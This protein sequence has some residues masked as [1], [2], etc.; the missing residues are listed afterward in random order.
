MNRDSVPN[1]PKVPDLPVI[2]EDLPYQDHS[3]FELY[4]ILLENNIKVDVT[5]LSWGG[6][7]DMV[8]KHNIEVPDA[9]YSAP[10]WMLEMGRYEEFAIRINNPMFYI[11]ENDI[12]RGTDG[13][14]YLVDT[15]YFDNDDITV[16]YDNNNS[17]EDVRNACRVT[18][19]DIKTG[20]Q[21]FMTGWDFLR[22]I[23]CLDIQYEKSRWMEYVNK[24]N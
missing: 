17:D 12:F 9:S 11:M 16:F 7:I 5:Q 2:N 21:K 19:T 20:Q 8:C 23:D 22:T 4:S 10:E 15:I 3:L 1:V 18:L 24:A 14:R 6:L 13:K